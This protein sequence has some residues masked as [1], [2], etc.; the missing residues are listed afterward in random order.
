MRGRLSIAIVATPL[1]NVPPRGYGPVERLMA[2]LASGLS[3]RGHAVAV[4]SRVGPYSLPGAMEGISDTSASE[5]DTLF[6]YEPSWELFTANTYKAIERGR[7]DVVHENTNHGFVSL[8]AADTSAARIG[9][10]HTAIPPAQVL[11]LRELQD[12]IAWIAVSGTQR[13]AARGVAFLGTIPNAVDLRSLGYSTSK[14]DYLLHLGRIH[15]EKGQAV[16][17]EVAARA[18]VRLVLAGKIDQRCPEYF[19]QR[20]RPH[21]GQR[22]SWI[23]EVAGSERAA[24]LAG[25]RGLLF[26]IDYEEA[27]G[28]AMAEAMASGT[29]VVATPRGA[30]VELVVPGVTGWLASGPEELAL[31]VDRLGEIDVRGCAAHA[32]KRFRPS[33]MVDAYEAAYREVA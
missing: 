7:F 29:P 2:M 30:A 20:V 5:A 28:L 19:E 3:K 26:P 21:L 33:G 6:G 27:F 4:F 13:A 8:A 24:L 31:A 15:P 11:L 16:A 17:I 9:T 22:V 25:A 1:Y 10:V 12:R 18:G 32:R 23:P 14:G